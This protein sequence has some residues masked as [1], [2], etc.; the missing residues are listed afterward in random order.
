MSVSLIER[1]IGY[2]K[3][4]TANISSAA[5]SGSTTVFV[6]FTH[7][8]STGQV[9]YVK[10]TIS[11][12]NGFKRITVTNV[13]DFEIRNLDSTDVPF[14]KST[15]GTVA[16][17][18]GS[19]DFHGWHCVH[20]PIVYKLTN[21]LWP[22]NSADTTRDITNVTN[23]NGYSALTLSGDVKATGSAEVLDF[24]KI[25]G[26]TNTDLNGIWQI[27][28]YTSDTSFTIS[29]PYD[30]GF[31]TDLTN[32]GS[33][34]YYYNNYVVK[35]QVW[36]GLNNGHEYYA[37]KPYELLATLNLIPDEDNICKFSIHEILQKQIEIEN[38]LLLGTL[39][40]NLD[41]FTMFF[42]K[43]GEEYDDS[44][45]IYIG[46]TSVSYTSDLA[47]F[48]GKAV[49]AALPFKN[50]YSG[51]MSEYLLNTSTAGKFLT[52]FEQPTLFTGKYF[53]LGF[54]WDGVTD[55]V[56]RIQKYLNGY[57]I[58]TEYGDFID[59]F[60]PGVYR[61]AIDYDGDCT[62]YDRFDITAFEMTGIATPAPT[63][64]TDYNAWDAKS[65]TQFTYN[66]SGAGAG[67]SYFPLTTVIGDVVY[68]VFTI[69][70][71]GETTGNFDLNIQLTD[72]SQI[73]TS[74]SITQSVANGTTTVA[75]EFRATAP[76]TRLEINYF[77]NGAQP[78]VVTTTITIPSTYAKPITQISE[79]KTIAFDCNCVPTQAEDGIYISWLNNLGHF[80]YWLFTAYKDHITDI[81]DSGETEVNVFE[82]WPNSFGEFADT[83][84]RKQT[85]VEAREQI[86]VRS[87]HLTVAQVNALKSIKTSQL[88]QII[89]SIYDR[90][91][92][93]VDKD[94]FTSYKEENKLHEISFTI[95]YTDD[96]PSQKV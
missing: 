80:D 74:N 23:S 52:N 70:Q 63:V 40:N 64:W 71:S 4:S 49:N 20:L 29:I 45:Q 8:Y 85:F 58:A 27:V 55:V 35:V 47:S 21:T 84:N 93:I 30:S 83:S 72:N 24:V 43:H 88:V 48:E 19:T 92:V 31:D 2:L 12:Y 46:R 51:A 22:T 62:D 16:I 50:I 60:Y 56:F 67:Q 25:T 95:T 82:N 53:D 37:Q 76:G 73:T 75:C 59:S 11:A 79:T 3:G 1:P 14:I 68:I 86:L 96:V 77:A 87:Q 13:N 18:G 44:T 69:T 89:N 5:A 9:V 41:A 15:T 33:I 65:A 57:L 91:T 10:S 78:T 17:T 90:R 26:C 61:S 32:N 28:N 54:L 42:I 7:G 34:Q 39:P 38:N 94:S 36:G 66:R 6:V 81:E